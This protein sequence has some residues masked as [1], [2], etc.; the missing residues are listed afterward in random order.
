MYWNNPII[1]LTYP[2]SQDPIKD[3]LHNGVHC[4]FYDSAFDQ[5]QIQYQQKL[6]DLCDWTNLLT[7]TLA[8]PRATSPI[9]CQI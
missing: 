2:S 7:Q 6:Q 3:S 4:L 1:N 5:K 9:R 8:N